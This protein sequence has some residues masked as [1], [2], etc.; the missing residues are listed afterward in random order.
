MQIKKEEKERKEK[1]ESDKKPDFVKWFSELNKDSGK[2]AGGKG[3]NLSEIYNLKVP[4]PPG[5]VVTA[6]AYDYFITKAGL[7]NKIK[8]LISSVEYEDTKQLDDIAKEIRELI[9]NSKFP[10]E[11]EE[12]II[13]NRE[14]LQNQARTEAIAKEIQRSASTVE[15]YAHAH[16]LYSDL[17]KN[18]HTARTRA[19]WR[20]LPVSHWWQAYGIHTSGYDAY[21]YLDNAEANKW[22]GRDMMFEYKR[23]RE[24]GNAPLVYSRAV[25][26]FRGLANEL[27]KYKLTDDQ[28]YALAAAMEAFEDWKGQ[29]E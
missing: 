9:I 17:R 2:V 19:L 27:M 1:E 13:E 11:L 3:A 14:I 10:K 21:Y 6:Q 5:F 24:A 4:V 26:A 15:N 16:W 29:S 20:A 7:D 8:E 25:I 18:G 28:R 23:D 12:E 22:S